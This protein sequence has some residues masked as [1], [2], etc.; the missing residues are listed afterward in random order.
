EKAALWDKIGR[1]YLA[2][3]G[4]AEQA[5]V[6]FTQALCEDPTTPSYAADV[7][8]LASKSPESW[9]DV[10]QSCMDAQAQME[11]PWKHALLLT[12]ARWYDAKLARPDLAVPCF[13]MVLGADPTNDAALEGLTVIYRKA[14]QWP[15]LGQTLLVRA[16][17]P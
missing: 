10:L 14:Q 2:E 11:G 17:L 7:E 12:M 13:N 1:L 9:G 8:K 3:V 16:D 15:E 5:L 6:A 4:D